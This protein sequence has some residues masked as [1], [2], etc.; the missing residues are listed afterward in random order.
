MI[1]ELTLALP[2]L[3]A[4]SNGISAAVIQSRA[5]GIN[6][7]DFKSEGLVAIG[8]Y[9]ASNHDSNDE[10]IGGVG[11]AGGLVPGK[12]SRNGNTYSGQFYL[13]PDR[14]YNVETTI[15]YVARH[16]TFDF[17]FEEYT[18]TANL[19]F[20]QASKLFNI[21]YCDTLYYHEAASNKG[22]ANIRNTTGLDPTAV[23]TG[24]LSGNVQKDSPLA[25]AKG[26]LSLDTEGFS[27]NPDGTFW[28]SEEY[29]PGIYKIASDGSIIAYI[30][31]PE[32]V[33]PRIGGQYNFTSKAN[34]DSGRSPNAGF[35]GMTV[36][37]DGHTLFAVLQAATTQDGG[38]G[39]PYVRI[40]EWDIS[41]LV[42]VTS[43]RPGDN[44]GRKVK[45]VG[46]YAFKVP[47]S[48]KGKGRN[49]S[50]L[51]YLGHKTVGL[52]VRDGNGFGNSDTD[53]SYKHID[54]LDLSTATNLAG[55]KY[56]DATGAIAPGRVLASDIDLAA[57]STLIDYTSDLP[58]FGMHSSGKP[59]DPTLLAAK[60]ESLILLPTLPKSDDDKDFDKDEFFI[61]S[62]SDN[63]FQTKTGYMRAIGDY[64]AAYPQDV[65][66]Q[67][68]VFKVKLPGVN[69]SDL[70]ARLGLSK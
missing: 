16:H 6:P 69:R 51:I 46:E 33:L 54:I 3:F 30:T 26:M 9:S 39:T 28:V 21:T 56:D 50:D 52:L 12:Y 40:F 24:G 18:G 48:K 70:V 63:D 11:S 44:P 4:L 36:S 22:N 27:A 14:G 7:S 58:K 59:V 47:T 29:T 17:Q 41:S 38:D 67:L 55:T 13:Q 65:P 43:Y 19:A 2:V 1:S 31:P 45:L 35:E 64:S 60:I 66:T 8:Q 15:D 61:V 34:P 42:G 37:W 62:V 10:T 23:R 32:A 68:F 53:V 5:E 57:Y 49:V 20:S 25:E